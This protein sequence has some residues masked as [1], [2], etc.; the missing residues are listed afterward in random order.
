LDEPLWALWA[1]PLGLGLTA[2]VYGTAYIG[3]RL[4]AAQSHELATLA[5][6]ALDLPD[7]TLGV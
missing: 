4:G 7:D 5:T 1:L 3:Q 2:M 6:H